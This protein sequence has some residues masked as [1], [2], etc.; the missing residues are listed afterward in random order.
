MTWGMAPGIRRRRFRSRPGS[1]AASL[2]PERFR[3]EERVARV[4]PS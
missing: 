3:L 1:L 4:G 2:A